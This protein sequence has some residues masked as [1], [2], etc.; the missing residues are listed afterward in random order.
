VFV[1]SARK[2]KIDPFL[3]AAIS[4][5]ESSFGK[6]MPAGTNNPFGW[7]PHIPFDTIPQAIRQVTAGLDKG[8]I[9]Q[10][11]DTIPEIQRKWAPLGAGNDPTNLNSNWIKNVSNSYNAIE[12]TAGTGPKYPGSKKY[13]P[14]LEELIYDPIGSWFGGQYKAGPYGGHE[15]HVH[16]AGT[17]PRLL[18]NSIRLARRLGL[19]VG[20]NPY[21][22]KV[23]PVHAG[24][25]A[26]YGDESGSGSPS[27]HY[28]TFEGLFGP[29]DKPLGEAIDVTGSP[30]GLARFFQNRLLRAGKMYTPLGGA[31]GGTAGGAGVYGDPVNNATS[32]RNANEWQA[33]ELARANSLYGAI[34]DA[35]AEGAPVVARRKRGKKYIDNL[36]QNLM[37]NQ[38]GA[39]MMGR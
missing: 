30:E 23:Y 15:T 34:F 26:Q 22:G 31:Y 37:Q 8:Y 7:G 33:A 5:A 25:S 3:L 14:G 27:Y 12:K 18:M 19:T 38:M 6:E 2:R 21:T 28:Q 1:R 9:K 32:V 20:E 4:G 39:T 17:N 16:L 11:L 24:Q 36:I 13:L 35:S 29:K 10:G